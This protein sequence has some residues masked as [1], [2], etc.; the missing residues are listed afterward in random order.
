MRTRYKPGQFL[1]LQDPMLLKLTGVLPFLVRIDVM[2]S[3]GS[4]GLTMGIT[5]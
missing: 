5:W 1:L 3:V 2:P 4:F